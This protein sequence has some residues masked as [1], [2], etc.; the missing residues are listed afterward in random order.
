MSMGFSFS[1]RNN[2]RAASH[3]GLNL[4]P[5]ADYRVISG[6]VTLDFFVLAG[7]ADHNGV[8]NFDDC[9][10]IDLAFNT[11]GSPLRRGFFSL[12]V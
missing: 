6:A 8:I 4:L 3:A 10:I 7:D 2:C 12:S 1:S 5:N 11:Q 9:A